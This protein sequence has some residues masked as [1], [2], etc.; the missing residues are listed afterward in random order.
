M[1]KQYFTDMNDNGLRKAATYASVSVASTLIVAKIVAYFMTDSVSM[2]SSLMDSTMDALASLIT[3]FGVARAMRPPD[4]DHRFGHGKAEP[5]ASLAQA[6]F[7]LGSS[8]LLCTEAVGRFFKPREVQNETV[9]YIVM[10]LAIVL[11]LALL[12]LQH[13]VIKRTNSLAIG[14]DRLHYIGDVLSNGAVILSLALQGIMKL[15]WIDSVFAIGIALAMGISAVKIARHSLNVLMDQELPE[16]DRSRIMDLAK[17][18]K[19]VLGAHDL[20]TRTDSGRVFIEIHVEM[21][22]NITVRAAH[23]IAEEVMGIIESEFP[24]ADV[25]VHQDPFGIEEKRLDT[26]IEPTDGL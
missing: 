16:T 15:T 23:D 8:A 7:I 4:R 10:L 12:R 25:L 3:A 9:G 26:Q 1:N 19:G 17:S 14:A 5:L 11:T 18:K 13:Y 6:T 2:L 20:R 22:Q 24:N 21:D